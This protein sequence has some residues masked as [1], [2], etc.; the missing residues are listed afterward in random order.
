MK[1]EVKIFA[2]D[3][4]NNNYGLSN[5]WVVYDMENNYEVYLETTNKDK[6]SKVHAS[7]FKNQ[8]DAIDFIVKMDKL[9][10]N[11]RPLNLSDYSEFILCWNKLPVEAWN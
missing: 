10:T 4:S 9:C 2:I 3:A 5:R 8:D 1:K 6:V 7:T 11:G